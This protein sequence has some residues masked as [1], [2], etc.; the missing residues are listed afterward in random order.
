MKFLATATNTNY[1]LNLA[2]ED[3]SSCHLSVRNKLNITHLHKKL[4]NE[5]H[6]FNLI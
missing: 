5:A 3:C 2:V 1:I 4:Q 6:I